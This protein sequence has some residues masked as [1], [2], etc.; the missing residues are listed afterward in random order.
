M[1]SKT[2]SVFDFIICGGGMAGLSLAY[3]LSQSK[4]SDKKILILDIEK[5]SKNDRTWAFWDNEKSDFE[6]ILYKKWKKIAIVNLQGDKF[7]I[8]LADYSYKLI[9]G[10]DFYE[11]IYKR[12]D[13]FSNIH[14]SNEKVVN[15]SQYT[16]QRALVETQSGTKYAAPWVFDSIF[17]LDLNHPF[18]L[19][20]L[21][22]FKGWVIEADEVLFDTEIPEMMN[23]SIPQKET[24]GRFI[25]ILPFSTTRALVEFTV[26]S[27]NLLKEE[28]YDKELSDFLHQKLGHG[29]Y[30]I[31][32]Q[33]FGVIPMSNTSIT[34]F[35]SASVVRIGTSGGYTNPATGYT[36]ANTQRHLKK[37]VEMLEKN[38]SP[39]I[40][41]KKFEFRHR[42]YASTLLYVLKKDLHPM[43]L[44]FENIFKKNPIQRIFKFLDNRS[45]I[46]DEMLI[47]RS[48]PIKKFGKAFFEIIVMSLYRKRA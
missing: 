21:Q 7:T 25:Y 29:S 31:L 20:Y 39:K 24:E 45:T 37:L 26:F 41:K 30:K 40:V 36:F 46:W 33:E 48:T 14:F 1:L 11:H 4:L 15:I 10:I 28:E 13:Q 17:K 23:F 8:S 38:N 16:N 42:L 18:N 12:L 44:T 47:M 9:R 32:E 3:Y 35:P 43:A 27:E 2:E 34:E 22:H 5:K 6:S 19:N